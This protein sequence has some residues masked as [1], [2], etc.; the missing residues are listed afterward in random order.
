DAVRNGNSIRM[1]TPWMSRRFAVGDRVAMDRCWRFV[2]VAMVDRGW[3]QP[4]FGAGRLMLDRDLLGWVLLDRT[5]IRFGG[6]LWWLISTIELGLAILMSV[7]RWICAAACSLDP[8]LKMQLGILLAA[9]DAMDDCSVPR[10]VLGSLDDRAI[11]PWT[12]FGMPLLLP[13]SSALP[14]PMKADADT[15]LLGVR[16]EGLLER[17]GCTN[18][19]ISWARLRRDLG[20]C[21]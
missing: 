20:L 4:R 14:C 15:L 5:R 7:I 11:W 1:R 2:L 13:N 21:Y 17:D 16:W 3:D 18:C 10:W 19:A 8:G 6:D 9:I 12:L